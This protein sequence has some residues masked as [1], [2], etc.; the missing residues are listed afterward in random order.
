MY[1]RFLP[2]IVLTLTLC[3][4]TS[5]VWGHVKYKQGRKDKYHE[6]MRSVT[7]DP[8]ARIGIATRDEQVLY[9]KGLCFSCHG[10]LI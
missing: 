7:G 6:I 3:F 9:P 1:K 8:E 5:A 10:S 4:M 2:Y